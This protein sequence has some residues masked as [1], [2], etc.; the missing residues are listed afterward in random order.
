[1]GHDLESCTTEIGIIKMPFLGFNIAFVDTPGLDNPKISDSDIL[2]MI[3]D[4]LAKTYVVPERNAG[5]ADPLTALDLHV[6]FCLAASSISIGYQ[7]IAWLGHL[8][9]TYTYYRDFVGE[10]HSRTL[11]SPPLCGTR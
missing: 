2:K 1:V 6:K 8:V 11:S 5:V 7:T 9:G 4:F 10:M 3:S